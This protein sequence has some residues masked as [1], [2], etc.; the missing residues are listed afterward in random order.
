MAGEEFG[1]GQAEQGRCGNIIGK[2]GQRMQRPIHS[3]GSHSGFAER[4]LHGPSSSIHSRLSKV[5]QGMNVFLSLQESKQPRM[6][7]TE[8]CKFGLADFRFE[9]YPKS[10]FTHLTICRQAPIILSTNRLTTY[11][12]TPLAR[13]SLRNPS[14][15]RRVPGQQRNAQKQQKYMKLRNMT[16]LEHSVSSYGI[17]IGAPFNVFQ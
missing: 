10:L 15:G 11:G 4:D 5:E 3:V 7:L 17:P 1:V 6:L 14:D 9:P 13:S 8:N 16:I 2:R 12:L